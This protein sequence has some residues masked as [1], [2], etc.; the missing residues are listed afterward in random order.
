MC[1]RFAVLIVLVFA[2]TLVP[3]AFAHQT[4]NTRR[5]PAQCQALKNPHK[6]KA[7]IQ[8]VSRPKPHHFHP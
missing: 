3:G 8:C 2:L 4:K 7:C 6:V 1:R 5:T